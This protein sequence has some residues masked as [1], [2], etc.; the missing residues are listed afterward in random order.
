VLLVEAGGEDN[1]IWL[2]IPAGYLRAIGDPRADWLL[3]TESEAGLGGRQL[4]Y[5]RG[6]VLGGS[7]AINGMI[8]M[9]GQAADYDGWR[10]LG[11]TGWGWDDVLPLFKG[12]ED[13]F[14]GADEFH[15]SGGEWRIEA[16]RIRWSSRPHRRRLRRV[17][18]PRT[19]DFNR[20]DNEGVAYFRSIR[21][22]AGAGARPEVPGAGARRPI[23]GW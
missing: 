1:W 12:H 7:S 23:C 6:K 22:A 15:G 2:H 8:Y 3:T 11:L 14:R 5:P 17:G 4:N 13:Y 16:P 19:E 10:Q 20:G 21:S 9:R 18:I